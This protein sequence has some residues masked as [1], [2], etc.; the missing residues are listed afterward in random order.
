MSDP[1]PYSPALDEPYS[2]SIAIL[3]KVA[4]THSLLVFRLRSGGLGL[5]PPELL[6]T[7]RILR[8]PVWVPEEGR[9][10]LLP[11][12]HSPTTQAE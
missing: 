9:L 3:I 11:A 1:L 8:I 10:R 4:L 7:A 12:L 6:P 2:P 5:L